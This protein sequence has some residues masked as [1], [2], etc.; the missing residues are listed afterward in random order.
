MHD[1]PSWTGRLAALQTNSKLWNMW[2]TNWNTHFQILSMQ[3]KQN[4][5]T[6]LY[7]QLT[8]LNAYNSC[9]WGL[10]NTK[11]MHTCTNHTTLVP[12]NFRNIYVSTYLFSENE[13]LNDDFASLLHALSIY[14]WPLCNME[15][16]GWQ[17]IRGIELPKIY[18]PRI[19][20]QTP[21]RRPHTRNMQWHSTRNM[22]YQ[23]PGRH[24]SLFEL[25][26]TTVHR[27]M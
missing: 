22:Q 5:N 4:G 2:Q 23:T 24:F 17:I 20:M 18:L 14:F 19:Q 8:N 9:N 3:P 13:S 16:W 11:Q 25:Y 15:Q 1:L 7:M 12:C 26:L 27:R 21:V 6:H 10:K